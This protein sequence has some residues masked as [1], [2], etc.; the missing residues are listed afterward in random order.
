MVSD[1]HTHL[2]YHEEL[3]LKTIDLSRFFLS[4]AVF[5]HASDHEV[6]T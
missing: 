4:L 2:I 1:A 3:Y 6:R 5:A